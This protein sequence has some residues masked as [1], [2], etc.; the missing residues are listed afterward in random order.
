MKKTPMLS[1][2]IE[3][4]EG[5]ESQGT[6]ETRKYVDVQAAKEALSECNLHSG[7]VDALC[8]IVDDLP[9]AVI[10]SDDLVS[11]AGLLA[12]YD[13]L[14]KG[15]P[16]GVRKII[17]GFPAADA[18]PVVLCR[19]CKHYRFD[20]C[21]QQMA[22]VEDADEFDGYFIGFLR[23]PNPDWFCAD[24]EKREADEE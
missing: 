7:I 9:A 20:P 19:D 21:E 22:C 18:R 5:A 23:Y 11:R 24:G 8:S 10:D 16:G 14:H 6:F 1:C 2:P 13:R 12:E 17:E 4:K 15:S 3:A